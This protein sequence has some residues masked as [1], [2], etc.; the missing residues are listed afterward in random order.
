MYLAVVDNK[1]L[2]IDIQEMVF[3]FQ[4]DP[5]EM[6][7][8]VFLPEKTGTAALVVVAGWSVLMLFRVFSAIGVLISWG[9]EYGFSA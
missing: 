2:P 3:E 1:K 9:I 8:Q 7:A 6:Q 4:Y 5:E